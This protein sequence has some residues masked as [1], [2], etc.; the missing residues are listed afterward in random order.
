MQHLKKRS[1]AVA[2]GA[3]ALLLLV[4]L[5]CSTRLSHQIKKLV[6]QTKVRASK[7]RGVAPRL[8]AITGKTNLPGAQVQALDSRSGWATLCDL[9]GNFRL[10]DVMWYAGASYELIVSTDYRQGKRVRVPAP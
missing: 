2:C 5:L 3:S 9:E 7:W 10:P 1:I 6:A 8:V 4:G